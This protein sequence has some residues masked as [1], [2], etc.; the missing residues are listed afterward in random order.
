M[1]CSD[2]DELSICRLDAINSGI[3]QRDCCKAQNVRSATGNIEDA[4]CGVFV[5]VDCGE[6]WGRE[7]IYADW[8]R[9]RKLK[10]L[11]LGRLRVPFM[12][13]LSI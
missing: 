11:C 5:P 12:F 8:Y 7:P 2:Y 3:E 6:L 9:S 1:L 13:R 10:W 4:C